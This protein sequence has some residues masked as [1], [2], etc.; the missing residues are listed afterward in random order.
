MNIRIYCIRTRVSVS[1]NQYWV[2]VQNM[3]MLL[4]P[5]KLFIS[6]NTHTYVCTYVQHV[7]TYNMY[8]LVGAIH[9]H[10]FMNTQAHGHSF[11]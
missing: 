10:A 5:K 4:L 1:V 6:K 3:E 2:H 7:H 9:C 8:V 11:K